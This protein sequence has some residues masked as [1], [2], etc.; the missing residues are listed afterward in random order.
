MTDPAID[1]QTLFHTALAEAFGSEHAQ[2]D[3]QLRSSKH[4][5]FQANCAL[6]LAKVLRRPPRDVANELLVKVP[7]NGIIDRAEVSGPGFLNLWL[8]PQYLSESLARAFADLGL[9]PTENP[10]TI[11]VDYSSPNVAKEMHVGHLRGTIIGDALC[12]VLEALG[13]HVVRQNH[14]GDWG[15]PFGML[16]EH[17]LDLGAAASEASMTDLNAFYQAARKKFDEDAAF[18]ER[19]R[20]RVVALQAGDLQTLELWKKLVGAS[21][22]YFHRVYELLGVTL[23]DEHVAGESFYNPWLDEVV[24]GLIERNLAVTSDGAICMFLPGF[25]GR[26]QQ[27]LPLIIRK[28]DGGYGYAATDLTAVR[29][30]TR[31]LGATR[32][33]YVVGAP[34]AQH[35]SMVFAAATSAGWLTAP[36]RAEHV[37]FGA[38]LGAD[39]KMLRTRAGETIRLVDLLNEAVHRAM[40]IVTEK[41]PSLPEAERASIARAVGIGAV[42]YADLSNDKVKDYVFDWDRMLAFDGNTAPYLQYAHA[43]IRSIFR[44][45]EAA[46]PRAA[47]F[48]IADPAEKSLALAL[49]AFPTVVQDVGESLALHRI[50]TYLYDLATTFSSFYENC[51]VLKAAT[52]AQRDSRL[53]L[54]ELTARVLECGLGLLGIEAPEKM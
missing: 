17:L 5:D 20:L 39:K 38:V 46:M 15:T 53:G 13:H 19:A 28:Q 43:R 26:E 44:K 29:H 45:G 33:L 4:A 8:S 1:L 10:E 41:N 12:R 31:T 49:L 7:R 18:A 37:A 2:L 24:N 6:S 25:V 48:D 52:P 54:C 11:V 50:C 16:I 35:L 27:P 21:L 40:V 9:A 14:L 23:Q 32:I 3:P 42:K 22:R 47:V 34:Q 30:R 36:A 51:P